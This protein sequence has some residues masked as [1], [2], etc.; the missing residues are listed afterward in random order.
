MPEPTPGI[1]LSPDYPTYSPPTRPNLNAPRPTHDLNA[2]KRLDQHVSG[3]I[4]VVTV[5]AAQRNLEFRTFLRD[6]SVVLHLTEVARVLSSFV[7]AIDPEG[8]SGPQSFRPK[9]P[10]AYLIANRLIGPMPAN[11][12]SPFFL[13][14]PAALGRRC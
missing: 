9:Q 5:V 8:V 13:L 1:A 11:S 2:P 12:S 6:P 14:G 4:T 3:R 10:P 7:L